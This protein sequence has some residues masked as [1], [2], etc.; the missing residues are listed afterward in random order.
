MALLVTLTL[1]IIYHQM[2]GAPLYKAFWLILGV[3]V[4]FWV[5]SPRPQLYSLL[6]FAFFISILESS[7]T[8]PQRLRWLPLFSVSGP[9][10]MADMYLVFFC[11]FCGWRARL[12]ILSGLQKAV[13]L[14]SGKK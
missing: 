2:D 1:A 8:R 7:E 13:C 11:Y 4:M 6:L 10:C 14:R 9:I 12:L 5:W 3:T